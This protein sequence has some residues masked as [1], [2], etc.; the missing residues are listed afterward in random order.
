MVTGTEDTANANRNIH[1]PDPNLDTE[2][3]GLS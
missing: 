2:T 3:I 1:A